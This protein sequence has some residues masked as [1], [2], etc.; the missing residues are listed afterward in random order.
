MEHERHV[1][2]LSETTGVPV[3]WSRGLP[4]PGIISSHGREIKRRRKLLSPQNGM[5][6]HCSSGL[7][8][9][10]QLSDRL[11]LPFPPRQGGQGLPSAVSLG[12]SCLLMSCSYAK[13]E[14]DLNGAQI[15]LRE[16]EA[17]LNSKDAA[18]ATA[19]GDKKSLEGELEDLRDQIAQV[20]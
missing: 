8:R 20:R 11:S 18:L 5:L 13:K 12:V 3:H 4:W 15:K 7:S 2:S 6:L 14:S 9:D 19:L 17:A 1:L 10:W 16:Y